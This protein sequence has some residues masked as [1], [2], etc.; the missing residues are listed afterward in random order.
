MNYLQLDTV[1]ADKETHDIKD[2]ALMVAL[3]YEDHKVAAI[4]LFP[5]R[6]AFPERL[7]QNLAQYV[8][9]TNINSFIA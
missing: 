8:I 9:A 7:A 3:H 2:E 1:P 5:R 6:G 4:A